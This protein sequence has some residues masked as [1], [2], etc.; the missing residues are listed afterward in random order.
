MTPIYE[1]LDYRQYLREYYEF[2]KKEFAFF[3]YRYFASKI[4][5]DYSIL[6]RII[7]G[8]LHLSTRKI[9]PIVKACGLNEKES[10]Y[11]EAMVRFN[12]AKNDKD[13]KIFF[14]KMLSIKSVDTNVLV[15]NQ[16]TFFQKWYYTAIW[17]ILN[18]K[19]FT[20]SMAELGQMLDPPLSAKETKDAVQLLTQLDLIDISDTNTITAKGKNITTGPKW[21]AIAIAQYQKIMLQLAQESIERFD[22]QYRDISTVTVNIPKKAIG[23]LREY[24]AEF[25]KSLIKLA[26]SYPESDSVYQ[27]NVQLFPLTKVDE[28]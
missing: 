19:P 17:V 27:L 21:H 16:Y 15:E 14:E 7:Q 20:G 11:F 25:R 26:D 4:G 3:S 10:E 18:Q 22:K 23:E 24:V 5:M 9:Q 1:Y 6:I 13:G 12:K 2:R 28:K 8:S